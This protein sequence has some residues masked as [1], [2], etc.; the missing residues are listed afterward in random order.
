MRWRAYRFDKEE[1]SSCPGGE[2]EIAIFVFKFTKLQCLDT[3]RDPGSS[4]DD[5]NS[6]RRCVCT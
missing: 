3:D 1:E 2:G 5:E 4:Q 6:F